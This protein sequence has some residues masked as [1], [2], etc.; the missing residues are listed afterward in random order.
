MQQPVGARQR[1]DGV[2]DQAVQGRAD[3][4][5]RAVENLTGVKLATAEYVDW[6]KPPDSAARPAPDRHNT[7][8]PQVTVTT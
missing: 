7:T 3:Q 5:V 6:N 2:D 8:E 4:T 1:V